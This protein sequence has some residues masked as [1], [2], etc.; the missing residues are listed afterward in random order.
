M[1]FYGRSVLPGIGTVVGLG[2]AGPWVVGL[3]VVGPGVD[4]LGV[5]GPGVDGL[6]VVGPGVVGL[7]VVGAGVGG[8]D[9]HYQERFTLS[10]EVYILKRDLHFLDTLTLLT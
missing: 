9:W 6:G 5:L 10:S 2:V 8:L 7:G 4:G 1:G 3:G